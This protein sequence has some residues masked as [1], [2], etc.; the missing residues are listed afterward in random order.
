MSDLRAWCGILNRSIT[1]QN[2]KRCSRRSGHR[3]KP[4]VM[5]GLLHDQV[6]SSLDLS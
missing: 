1:A 2:G 6:T 5:G 3:L 4:A